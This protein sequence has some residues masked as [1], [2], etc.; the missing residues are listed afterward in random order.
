MKLRI[1]HRIHYRYS[2][3]VTLAPQRVLL[4]PREHHHASVLS[5]RLDVNPR[6]KIFWARDANEN[7]LASVHVH[8]RCAEFSVHATSEVETLDA[9]PFDFLLISEAARHPFHYSASDAAALAPFLEPPRGR[10]HPLLAWLRSIMPQFPDDTLA[11]LTQLNRTLRDQIHV[12]PKLRPDIQSP[13]QTIQARSGTCRDIANLMTH[14]CRALGI[15]ARYVSGYR[16]DERDTFGLHAWT[17]VYLPGA[18]W[19]GFDP[20]TALL[21]DDHY[22]SVAAGSGPEQLAPVAGTFWS[23]PATTSTMETTVEVA[24]L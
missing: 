8:E 1:S 23:S 17:E 16:F 20:S 24:R 14:A 12:Q 19:K 18:G 5:F 21:S 3:P 9:N 15:A 11:L 10:S 7:S 6:A 13:E 2:E 4:R 22:V